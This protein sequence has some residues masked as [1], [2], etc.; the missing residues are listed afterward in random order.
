MN[1]KLPAFNLRSFEL[2]FEPNFIPLEIRAKRRVVTVHDFSFE[3]HPQW[4]PKER[5]EHF[6]GNFWKNIG[7]ADRIIVPSDFIRDEAVNRFGLPAEK[8]RRIHNGFSREQFHPCAPAETAAVRQKYSLPENFILFVGSMEPRKNILNLLKA[9]AGLGAA[10][11]KDL[12]LVL[13]GFKG[14]EN[15]EIMDLIGKV[16]EDVLY[17]GYL[18][19]AEL[20]ALYNL[21][22]LFAYPSRYEGFGL[23][24]LEAMA[25][26]CPVVV[27]RAASL[28]EVCGGAA[29]YVD[30]LD[31]ESIAEGLRKVAQDEPLRKTMRAAGLERA[32]LFSWESSAREHLKLFKEVCNR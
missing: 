3:L 23:P 16:K 1:R 8:V 11:R 20:G 18:Q 29:V 21:A 9:Y 5:V 19:D 13:A 26:G 17:L 30:P 25:C 7:R 10:L 22:V 32:R 24:P 27:S 12:K 14:W 2:Y 15:R 28:P 6:A 31:T 4:H